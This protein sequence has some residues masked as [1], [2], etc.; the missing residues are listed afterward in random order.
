MY[1]L[2]VLEEHW[3][4]TDF[5]LCLNLIFF[6][7]QDSGSFYGTEKKSRKGQGN[8]LVNYPL[9]HHF[10]MNCVPYHASWLSVNNYVK[11]L[12]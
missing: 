10:H 2:R 4:Q 12:R 3:I 9:S 1:A 6:S 7:P 5:A 8:S 11:V